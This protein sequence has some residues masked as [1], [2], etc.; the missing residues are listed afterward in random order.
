MLV[1][2]GVG[3]T[4]YVHYSCAYPTGRGPT[5]GFYPFLQNLFPLQL[6]RRW[7]F[8]PATGC[9]RLLALDLLNPEVMSG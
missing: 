5:V 3:K 6:M 2:G 4:R 8:A 7:H 9:F 1:K